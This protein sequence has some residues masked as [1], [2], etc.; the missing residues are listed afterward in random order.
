MKLKWIDWNYGL[1]FFIPLVLVYV[2][3]E[4]GILSGD[5][6]FIYYIVAL[7]PIIYLKV[8]FPFKRNRDLKKFA[9]LE[10]YKFFKHPL[11]KQLNE[12]RNFKSLLRIRDD[13]YLQFKNLL[14]PIDKTYSSKRPTI[15]SNIE[16]YT[17]TSIYGS[18]TNY[19]Y[20]QLFLFET[21]RKLPI[22]Y[23]ESLK[24]SKSFFTKKINFLSEKKKIEL[25][26]ANYKEIELFQNNFPL[27]KYKLHSPEKNIVNS[28]DASFIELLNGGAKKGVAIDIESDGKNIVFY[29][30]RA[31]HSIEHMKFF[32]EIFSSMLESITTE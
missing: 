24:G 21:E 2:F 15:A 9:K 27:H 28:I 13:K 5:L 32:C 23:L 18:S 7:I 29:I 1:I 17:H 6:F 20:T 19:T 4:F 11:P 3:A 30:L 8:Y 26:M 14:T 25:D 10:N 31:R 12:F 16:G 22:F